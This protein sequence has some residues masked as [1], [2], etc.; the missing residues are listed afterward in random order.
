MR[1][2]RRRRSNDTCDACELLNEASP[3]DAGEFSS[4]ALVMS[5]S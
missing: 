1:A 4:V 3:K 2:S 5:T